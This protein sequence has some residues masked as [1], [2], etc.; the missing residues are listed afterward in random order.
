[1][2]THSGKNKLLDYMKFV[3]SMIYSTKIILDSAIIFNEIGI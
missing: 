1:M 3:N 2:Q